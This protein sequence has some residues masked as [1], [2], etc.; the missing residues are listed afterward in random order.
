MENIEK[1]KPFFSVVIPCYNSRKTLP[2]LL[3]SIIMQNMDYSEIQVV[4]S[5]DCSPESYQD[6]VDK[7]K[8]I[9][10]ITQTKTDYNC[11]PGNT[12]QKGI[13]AAQGEWVIFSDHD[14][15]FLPDTFKKVKE[16]IQK[17]GFDT[18]LFAR[19]AKR[20]LNGD[21]VQMPPNAGWTHGK[22]FNREFWNKYE[23]SYTKD[24]TSH[25]DVCLSTQLEYLRLTYGITYYQIDLF[26]YIWNEVSDSLS[27]RKYTEAKKERVFLDVFLTDY[28]ESTAGISYAMYLKHDKRN[29]EWVC[30]QIKKVL[31]Y[32][33]FYSE[34]SMD[35]VPEYLKRNFDHVKK[36]LILLRDEFD[37]SVDDIYHYFKTEHKE[38][39]P[40]I[41]RMAV[42]QTADFLYERSFREW[43]YWIWDEKYK[44]HGV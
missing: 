3:N 21:L 28:I 15:E 32:A 38:E 30:D 14:D 41:F 16:A 1:K 5:D 29:K 35:V 22:F 12:R 25:E 2:A 23:L 4:L 33:Y 20:T 36:Y 7:Y 42:S 40:I 27:N 34:F 17:E 37:C 6:V 19:F 8:N 10:Y 39:Y 43:L 13:Q 44:E 24:L 26:V 18:V 9:L 31:L 11:C